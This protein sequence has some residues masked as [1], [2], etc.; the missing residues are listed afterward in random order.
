MILPAK[1]LAR[2]A[3][4][5]VLHARQ[6]A[7]E[8]DR[9]ATLTVDEWRATLDQHGRICFYCSSP[10]RLV[11]SHIVPLEAG[12]DSVAQNVVPACR[13]CHTKKIRGDLQVAG[14]GNMTANPRALVH[15]W[16]HFAARCGAEDAAR[17]STSEVEVTC[18]A[19]QERTP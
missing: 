19:C 3:R 12:G 9:D 6:R 14:L 17:L 16:D 1:I 10:H 8:L 15:R 11:L 18:E 4:F 5:Q 2:R 7:R 13:S